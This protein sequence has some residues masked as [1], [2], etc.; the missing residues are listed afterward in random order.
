MPGPGTYSGDS[1][2]H[3]YAA[4]PKFGF[5]NAS[6]DNLGNTPAPGPGAYSP[7]E[8]HS[9]RPNSPRHGFGSSTRAQ[10]SGKEGTP[11]PGA[12]TDK[13]RLG[14]E[15]SNYTMGSKAKDGRLLDGPGPGTYDH[16]VSAG[17]QLSPRYGFGSATRN[18][19]QRAS[20]P[21]PGAY[22]EKQLDKGKHHS[23][24]VR[25]NVSHDSRTPGPGAHEHTSMF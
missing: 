22:V 11:G 7:L 15:A 6:R 21:G 20:N 25:N 9:L 2:V 18:S 14:K 23:F 13:E 24:G 16:R 8:A 4:V 19:T 12:Y 10:S 3:K 5:G 17:Q 1:N